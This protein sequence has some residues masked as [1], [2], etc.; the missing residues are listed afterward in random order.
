MDEELKEYVDEL[1]AEMRGG[2]RELNGG[3]EELRGGFGS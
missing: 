3:L 2:F 1:R